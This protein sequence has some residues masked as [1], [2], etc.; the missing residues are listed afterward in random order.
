MD[1]IHNLIVL[2]YVPHI[3]KR[4]D[5]ERA[6]KQKGSLKSGVCAGLPQKLG[7]EAEAFEYIIGHKATNSLRLYTQ[8]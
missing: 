3:G 4:F 8:Y 7:H 6:L 1:Q 5:W 2:F